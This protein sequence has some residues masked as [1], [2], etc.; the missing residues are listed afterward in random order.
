MQYRHD[1]DGLRALAVMA[2]IIFHLGFLDNGYLGVDVFFVISGYL[3]TSIIYREKSEGRFSLK[4]FYERRI[5]RILPLLLVCTFAVLPVGIYLMMPGDLY[6]LARSVIASNLSANNILL[7]LTSGGYWEVDNDYRPLMHTWSLAVEEQFYII[8]P[9]I[10]LFVSSKRIKLI[11]YIIL[12]LTICSL[13]VFILESDENKKFFLLQYRFFELSLGG[14]AALWLSERKFPR[15]IPVIVL[16]VSSVILLFLLGGICKIH[17]DAQIVITV[18]ATVGILVFGR[19]F[20]S[21]KNLYS[22]V[23]QNPVVLFTGKISFSLYMWHQIVFAFARISYV[24]KITPASGVVLTVITFALATLSYYFVEN[25]F[26]KR[27]KIAYTRVLIFLLLLFTVSNVLAAYIFSRKAVLKDFPV[28]SVDK[29]EIPSQPFYVFGNSNVLMDYNKRISELNVPFAGNKTK[30]LAIGDSYGRDAANIFLESTVQDRIELRYI[31]YANLHT[32]S[33]NASLISDADLYVIS[34]DDYMSKKLL[35]E[36][37]LIGNKVIREDQMMFLGT[38]I[39]A[40]A[41]HIGYHYFKSKDFSQ[42][43][44]YNYT[45]KIKESFVPLNQKLKDEWGER[46]LD[47]MSPLLTGENHIKIY[48]PDGKMITSDGIHLT[49]AGACYYAKIF[50]HKVNTFIKSIKKVPEE[51][52]IK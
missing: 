8:Y 28:F 26:R 49:P 38:K 34:F 33:V 3:I 11:Q 37:S 15:I 43:Q 44:R 47:V 32:G 46:Y 5:R 6:A 17:N 7:Y 27:E 41:N 40:S 31:D 50:D 1:I 39:F 16:S 12:L 4:K 9:L 30:V 18:F 10:F 24:E 48:A 20:T 45:T 36:I 29:D 2:V 21:F 22:L 51:P 19:F 13:A 25:Y 42:S 35:R 14:L 23:F 52:N